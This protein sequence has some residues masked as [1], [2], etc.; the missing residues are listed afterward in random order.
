MK[1]LSISLFWVLLMC[2]LL[3]GNGYASN[4]VINPG[5]ALAANASALAAFNRAAASWGNLFSDPITVTI[6]A[7]LAALGPGILGSTSSVM[8]MGDYN[9]IRDQMVADAADEASNAIVASLPTAAQFSAFVP[10]GFGIQNAMAGTKANLKAMGFGGLDTIFGDSD[11]DI[12]FSTGFAFDYD[13]SNGVGAGLYDFETVA[14]HEIGHVLGF[15]SVVDTVDWLKEHNQVDDVVL[16]PLDLFRF[17]SG[18][19]PDSAADFTAYPRSLLTGGASSFSDVDHTW[20]FSTGYYTGDGNQ[21][22]HWKEG[23][24]IG[25]MNPTLASGT[26]VNISAADIRALDV[27]GWDVASTVPPGV[28]EPSTLILLGT[29]LVSIIAAAYRRKK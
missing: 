12:T 17:D 9:T 7:N 29:G 18:F 24:G 23:L 25:L 19:L 2:V 27:I 15:V 3:A 4:I 13:N 8:L 16:E 14:A 5:A 6:N 10:N 28:P 21:A 22:S 20:A 26:I 11:A 1:R